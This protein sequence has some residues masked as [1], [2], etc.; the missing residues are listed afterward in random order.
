VAESYE[1]LG[2]RDQAL[3]T[4]TR[5]LELGFSVEYGKKT[6]IFNALRKDPRSP[7]QVREP[8]VQKK[9]K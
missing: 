7:L 2:E 6:P 3:K 4:L 8:A 5:A 9:E 1:L